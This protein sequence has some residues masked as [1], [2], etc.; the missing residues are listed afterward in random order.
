MDIKEKLF[1]IFPRGRSSA[2]DYKLEVSK[3][4]TGHYL[5]TY[6]EMYDAPELSLYDLL[7][8]LSELFGTTKINIDNYGYAG[9]DTCDYGSEYGHVI[10]IKEATKNLTKLDKLSKLGNMYK[11]RL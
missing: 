4:K 9:C 8:G 2:R 5:I 3:V 1:E 6:G 11:E 10:H 7:T